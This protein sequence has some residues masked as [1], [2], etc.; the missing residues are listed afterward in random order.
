MATELDIN[1]GY[2]PEMYDSE[3]GKDC[4]TE[5]VVDITEDL[6]RDEEKR[7]YILLFTRAELGRIVQI[8]H[9]Y[10]GEKFMGVKIHFFVDELD[11]EMNAAPNDDVFGSWAKKMNLE[12]LEL[13][14]LIETH[15]PQA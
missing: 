15:A 12:K 7:R 1:D 3:T 13:R 2:S 9:P 6:K 11:A 8:V 10:E 4:V 14:A 5:K